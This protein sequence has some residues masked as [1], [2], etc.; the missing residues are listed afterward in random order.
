MSTPFF[1]QLSRCVIPALLLVAGVFVSLFFKSSKAEKPYSCAVFCESIDVEARLQAKAEKVLRAFGESEPIAVVTARVRTGYFESQEKTPSSSPTMESQQRV[2]ET[3]E[4]H[5]YQN[6]KVATNWVVG[7][8]QTSH[9]SFR[10]QIQRVSCLVQIS[11]HNRERR[12]EIED[13][14][15]VALGLDSERGDVALAAL[16]EKT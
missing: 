10:P 3:D 12:Q 2:R 5:S 14:V 7:E 9:R 11:D 6:E 4:S 16:R 15:A 13:A 8:L 1:R